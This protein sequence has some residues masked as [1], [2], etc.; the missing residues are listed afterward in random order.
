MPPSLDLYHKVKAVGWK[1]I[2]VTGR[3]EPSRAHTADNL[4][5]VGYSDYDLLILNSSIMSGSLGWALTKR[6]L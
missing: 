5:A 1:V 2:L 4:K 6:N 3:K